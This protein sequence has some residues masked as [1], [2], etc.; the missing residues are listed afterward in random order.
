MERRATP[1]AVL[2][3]L[4]VFLAL[5]LSGCSS[6]NPESEAPPATGTTADSPL[7]ADVRQSVESTKALSSAHL[8]VRSS[9]QVDSMLGITSA[10]VDVRSKPLAAKG[11]CTYNGQSD[12]P[13]RIKDD[14]ISVKL[15]DD[16]TNLGNVSDLSA[17]HMLD[18]TNGVAKLLS[19]VT[20]VQSQGPE[21]IDG[22][23]TTKINGT[24]PT[25]TVK[26]LDP[27]ARQSRPATVWIASDGSH[28]LVRAS[29][30]LGSG[31]VEVTLSKWNEPVNTD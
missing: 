22:I 26:I 25:D 3:A 14:T 11:S 29:V 27:G 10:D 1:L 18:P 15:F 7:M 12:V 19:G 16:W 4:G 8:A 21:V 5:W 2:A 20:N 31:S 9:G 6:E 23:P 30:D 24:L 28:R 13:F 17:S